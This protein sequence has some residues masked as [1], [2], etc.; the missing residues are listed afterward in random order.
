[1]MSQQHQQPKGKPDSFAARYGGSQL[2]KQQ[3][4]QIYNPIVAANNKVN[5]PSNNF[6]PNNNNNNIQRTSVA[7]PGMSSMNRSVSGAHA[8]SMTQQKASVSQPQMTVPAPTPVNKKRS[9]SNNTKRTDPPL[10]SEG[11]LSVLA[12]NNAPLIGQKIR[13]LLKSID[14]AYSM[15]SE[16]EQQVVRMADEFVEKLVSQSFKLAKHR[17]SQQ[18]EVKDVQLSLKKNW[19]IQIPGLASSIAAT[20]PPRTSNP[21]DWALNN[22]HRNQLSRQPT[23]GQLGKRK[24]NSSNGGGSMGGSNKKANTIGSVKVPTKGIRKTK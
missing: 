15:D 18:M 5:P 17:G 24:L 21:L 3:Q 1:M 4:Q 16:T 7:A 20:Q 2:N 6:R 14:S 23:S 8:T 12:T 10:D 9:I 13:D 19:G 11:K 22:F